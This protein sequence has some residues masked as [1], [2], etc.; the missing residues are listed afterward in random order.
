MLNRIAMN[1]LLQQRNEDLPLKVSTKRMRDMNEDILRGKWLELRGRVKEN[2]GKI[3]NN[4]IVEIEGKGE[5]LLGLLQK[6]YGYIR[7]KDEPEYKDTLEL[8]EIVTSIRKIMKTKENVRAILFIARYG[9][10]L[11]AKKSAVQMATQRT[12]DG[13]GTERYCDTRLSRRNTHV[14][15]Q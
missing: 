1:I 15:P 5:K 14:A 9:K 4:N 8:A 11:L 3:I 13:D 6:R 12:K 7:G 10:P 2:W